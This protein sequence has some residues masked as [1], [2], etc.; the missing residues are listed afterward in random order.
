MLIACTCWIQFL[1][2]VI[3]SISPNDKFWKSGKKFWTWIRCF[4]SFQVHVY[5]YIAVTGA[6]FVVFSG[7]MKESGNVSAKCSIVEDGIMVQITKEAL[8]EFKSKLTNMQV[9]TVKFNIIAIEGGFI[10]DSRK[11]CF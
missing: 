9:S 7:S 5:L 8:D 10:Y 1:I 4:Y 11:I 2:T 6:S 3:S